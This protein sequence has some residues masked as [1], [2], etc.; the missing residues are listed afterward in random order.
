MAQDKARYL[1][2]SS[3]LAE[4]EASPNP[5]VFVAMDSFAGGRSGWRGT[6]WVI[7]P[8][9]AGATPCTRNASCSIGI[10]RSACHGGTQ[11][12]IVAIAKQCGGDQRTQWHY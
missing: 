8:N 3:G 2:A 10:T 1:L 11:A 9:R 6:L 7:P 4:W 5:S 12:A